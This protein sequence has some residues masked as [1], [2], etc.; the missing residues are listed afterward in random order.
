MKSRKKRRKKF[1]RLAKNISN[2]KLPCENA[3]VILQN[4]IKKSSHEKMKIKLMSDMK[5]KT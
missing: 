5:K 1:T 4:F 3:E 2:R